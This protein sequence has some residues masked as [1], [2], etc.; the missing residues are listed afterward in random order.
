MSKRRILSLWFPRLNAECLL[1]AEPHLAGRP[2]AVVAN[3]RG[4]LRLASLTAT[5]EAAGLVLGMTLAD[6]AAICPRLATRPEAPLRTAAFL[7]A[8][9]RWAGRFSPWVAPAEDGLVLDVTGCA[10]LFGGEEALVAEAGAGAAGLGLTLRHG[11]ADTLGA[12]W[13]IARFDPGTGPCLAFAGDAIDQEAR[14]TRARAHRRR[15]LP[16]PQPGAGPAGRIVPPGETLAHLSPLPAAALRLE[17]ATVDALQALGLGRIGDVALVPRARLAQRFGPGLVL[18]IDQALGRVPEPV[19]AAVPPPVF[20][21]RLTLPDPIGR[22]ED[23]LAGL[24]RLLLPLCNRLAAAGRGA[25]RVQ[26]TLVRVEGSA[27]LREAGLARPASRREAIR[28]LLVLQL[29]SLDAGF[30]I[31]MMRLE[32]TE[33]EPLPT[34]QDRHRAAGSRTDPPPV[35]TDE[36]LADLVGRLGARLGVEA[37]VRLHP[38]ESHI[39]E[40][41]ATPMLAAFSSAA[42]TWPAPPAPRPVLLF[43][44]EPLTPQETACSQAPDQLLNPAVPPALFTWR[45]RPRRRTAAFGPERIAPEWWLDDPAWRGGP[46]DYWRIETEDGTRLWLYQ[47]RE[48]S[49][50]MSGRWFVQGLFA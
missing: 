4:A 8:L 47:T 49:G 10:R 42:A 43:P 28:P 30:G 22:T 33:T 35:E 15:G 14:A 9:G 6:A 37:M 23:I 25:R 32:A 7:A 39:P 3:R 18:R 5:A 11:L 34:R 20:A 48:T 12:A 36:A 46:R 41:A 38:A 21:L 2:L 17:P 45:R 26:L 31:E 19:S 24:D 50:D 27:I 16:G 13:A 44:P 29:D 40:K 1:R